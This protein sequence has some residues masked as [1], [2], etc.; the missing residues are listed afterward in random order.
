[1]H[2]CAAHAARN[3]PAGKAYKVYDEIVDL[4]YRHA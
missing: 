1:L 2:H 4:M 3:T